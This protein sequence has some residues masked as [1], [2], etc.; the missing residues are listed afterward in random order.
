M[1]LH[2]SV[3]QADVVQMLLVYGAD[4]TVR[5]NQGALPFH[6]AALPEMRTIIRVRI[7]V[8]IY[9]VG[10]DICIYSISMPG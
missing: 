10:V 8:Y 1:S 6:L 5:N 2:G 9:V 3:C 4:A 7:C